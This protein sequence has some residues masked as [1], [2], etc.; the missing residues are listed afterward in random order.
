[1][2]RL[3]L[4]LLLLAAT[5]VFAQ[6]WG[7]PGS[8][9]DIDDASETLFDTDGPTLKFKS[10]QT[11]TIVARYP[12]FSSVQDPGWTDLAV[13]YTGAGV[14]VKLIRLLYCN[15]FTNQLLSES[16][17]TGESNTCEGAA[18]PANSWDFT[19]WTYYVEVTL[20]RGS[21]ATDPQLHQLH[22]Q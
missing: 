9:G 12:V 11:G 4:V 18:V 19:Q 3:I 2:K 1:M 13:N 16:M 5:P 22:F 8:A 6:Y 17:P 7:V 10:G 20:T 21:T 14:S 15:K